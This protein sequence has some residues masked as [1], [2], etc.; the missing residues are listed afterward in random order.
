M[1]NDLETIKKNLG[2]IRSRITEIFEPLYANLVQKMK[3]IG[4]LEKENTELK[5]QLTFHKTT[6]ADETKVQAT[7]RT[8]DAINAA[9][10]NGVSGTLGGAIV[11]I[12][13]WLLT[14]VRVIVPTE[15]V[16]ALTVI[17][18]FAIN[19]ALARSG[20]ISEE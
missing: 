15:V 3:R 2:E 17:F 4:E 10:Y 5:R 8:G 7:E 20:I 16:V 19:I 1:N 6:M 13:A 18:S 12:F 14:Y 11:V 9:K